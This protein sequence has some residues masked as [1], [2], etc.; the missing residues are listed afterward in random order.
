MFVEMLLQN[1][2]PSKVS[3]MFSGTQ[4]KCAVCKKTVYPLEK[5]HNFLLVLYETISLGRPNKATETI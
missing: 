3:T 2:T 4:D 1:R 5:V